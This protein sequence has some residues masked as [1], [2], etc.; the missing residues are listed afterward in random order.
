[1]PYTPYFPSRQSMAAQIYP[2]RSAHQL[3]KRL[4]FV[5]RS[6]FYSTLYQRTLALFSPP[7]LQLVLHRHARAVEK[8]FKPYL[9]AKFNPQ[10]RHTMLA[11]HYWLLMQLWSRPALALYLERGL[12]LCRF[13][14]ADGRCLEVRLEYIPQFQREGELTLVMRMDGERF[15][16]VTFSLTQNEQ[17]QTGLF[18]GCLQGPGK[19]SPFNEDDIR[20]LTRHCFGV[21]PKVLALALLGMVAE[22]WHCRFIQAVSNQ[23]HIFSSRRYQRKSK[24]KTDYDALWVECGGEAIDAN[25]WALPVSLPRKPLEE[26]ASKK[27][28]QYRQRYQ[29]LD[30]LAVELTQGLSDVARLG[31]LYREG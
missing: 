28:S 23:G 10:Q 4:L 7:G 27:R 26:V 9:M 21:R 24:V 1:M 16:S 11:R 20:A 30:A 17:G 12:T 2:G 14:G 6:L 13:D 5:G 19:D 22:A 15:Y 25:L 31:T 8:I 29:W 18:I 3:K